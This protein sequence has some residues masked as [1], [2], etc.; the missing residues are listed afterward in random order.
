[1]GKVGLMFPG[2]GSQSVGMGK[3]L[4][5]SYPTAKR[6]FEEANEALGFDLA[7]LCFEGPEETLTLT[8]NTQ[9]AI[10]TASIAALRVLQE[11]AEFEVEFVAGH[12]LGEYSALVYAGAINFPDAVRTVR[13]RG[14]FMQDAVPVG[15]GTM[16]AIIGLAQ[17]EVEALCKQVNSDGNIVTLANLNS[18]GQ[19]VIS[20]HTKAVNDVVALAK[21]K[22]AKRA[23]PLAVSA[24]FHCALMRPAAEQLEKVLNAVSFSDLS[25]PLINNAEASI[26]ISGE[27]ARNSLVR[28]MYKS[29]QWEQSIRLMIE[30]GVTTCI[31]VGPGKVLSGLLR[32][33]DKNIKGLNVQDIETLERTTQLLREPQ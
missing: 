25:I 17:E 14:E 9:P 21:G 4:Y 28:Q 31:E 10:V 20:G 24:P 29:V 6:V 22:G 30:R 11:R 26:I 18:P 1:M 13:K 27:E 32:R 12:S 23:I 19:F 15:T 8:T 3:D 5:D 16:A 33:I 2:Q 7:K